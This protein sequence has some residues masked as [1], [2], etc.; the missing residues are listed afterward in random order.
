MDVEEFMS[1]VSGIGWL[2]TLLFI[3]VY[4]RTA[5]WWTNPYGRALFAVSISTLI[6]FTSS[7]LFNIFGPEYLGRTPI[8]IISQ[9]FN[10]LMIWYLLIVIIRGGVKA[11]AARRREKELVEDEY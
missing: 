9:S 5:F 3:G 1:I 4:H 10:T 7:G 11:R 8:R 6:F 2:G